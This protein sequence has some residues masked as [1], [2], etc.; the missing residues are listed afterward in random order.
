[1]NTCATYRDHPEDCCS[2]GNLPPAG[3]GAS[4]RRSN[5]DCKSPRTV[6]TARCRRADI[7]PVAP[8]ISDDI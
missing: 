2:T 8:S 3:A 7:S 1:M 4:E 6:L 5:T